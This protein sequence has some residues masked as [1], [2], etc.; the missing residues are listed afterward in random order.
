LSSP[1]NF[2]IRWPNGTHILK[3]AC[4]AIEYLYKRKYE[5]GSSNQNKYEE[6]VINTL[7]DMENPDIWR[8]SEIKYGIMGNLIRARRMLLLYQILFDNNVT[9]KV[10]MRV[11]RYLHIP[12]QYSLPEEKSDLKLLLKTQVLNYWLIDFL[13][14]LYFN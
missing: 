8:L 14:S 3:E 1:S 13:K 11:S 4:N 6:L 5:V 7:K 10:N 2:V 9:N 12:S